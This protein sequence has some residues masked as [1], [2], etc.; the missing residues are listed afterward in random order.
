MFNFNQKV[1]LAVQFI[2]YWLVLFISPLFLLPR[3]VNDGSWIVIYYIFIPLSFFP[4]IK[5]LNIQEKR[6]KK[7]FVIFGFFLPAILFY[8][9]F[10]F[11]ALESFNP[12]IL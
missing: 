3:L 10:L 12:E 7:I 11:L 2:L 6:T 9:Y 4:F 1:K 5:F 8:F